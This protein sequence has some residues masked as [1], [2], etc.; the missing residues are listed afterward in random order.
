MYGKKKEKM[1]V[2]INAFSAVVYSEIFNRTIV[3]IILCLFGA[4]QQ[5]NKFG[6]GKGE[7]DFLCGHFLGACS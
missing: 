3:P 4:P 7:I 5:L 2:I 1:N 6:F